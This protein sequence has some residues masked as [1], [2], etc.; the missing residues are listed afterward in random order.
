VILVDTSVWIDH[1]NGYDSD[2]AAYLLLRIADA[3]PLVIPGLVLTEILLGV[4]NESEAA[5]MTRVMSAFDLAPE[6]D[7]QDYEQAAELYRACRTRGITPRSTSDCLIARLCLRYGYEL[8]TKELDF[9]AISRC[10]PLR[11]ASLPKGV[12]D[13]AAAY[14]PPARPAATRPR[15]SAPRRSSRA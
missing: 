9:E 8:L 13:F 11:L 6:F 10:Y 14:G 12:Q 5:R 7:R 3:S 2:Q 1:F 4:R 15:A